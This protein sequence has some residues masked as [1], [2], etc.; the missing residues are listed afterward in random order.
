MN[1]DKKIVKKAREVAENLGVDHLFV[2]EMGEFFTDENLARLSVKGDGKKIRRLNFQAAVPAALPEDTPVEAMSIPAASDDDDDDDDDDEKGD[3]PPPPP[4]KYDALTDDAI[5]ADLIKREIK[6]A[7][8]LGRTKRIALLV[9]DD[10]KYF[11][12]EVTQQMLDINP[13][14]VA[15]GVK[16]GETIRV[17]KEPDT[18]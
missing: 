17:P 3:P 15:Q 8:N 11:E 9:A 2:N 16:L 18:K 10:E 6:F 7:K 4:G 12:T 1:V 14:L 5:E 13:E